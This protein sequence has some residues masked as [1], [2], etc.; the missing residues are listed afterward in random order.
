MLD[1]A[2]WL[3]NIKTRLGYPILHLAISDEMIDKQI[4][5]AIKKVVPYFN[6]TEVFTIFDRVTEFKDKLIYSV[7]RVSSNDTTDQ[8][9]TDDSYLWASYYYNT[10]SKSIVNTALWNYYTEEVNNTLFEVG[11]RFLGN[12]LYI[13]NGEP[14]YTVEAITENSLQ[15]MSEDY[16]NWC[17]EYSL[18]LVKVIEG[19]IR[20]KLKIEGSPIETNGSELK[21]E[22]TE[23]ISKLEE[24]LGSSLSLY[25]ATR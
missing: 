3:D 7:I 6:S 11:F 23:E 5:Y 13:D 18:A 12:T 16:V 19:E 2:E 15:N 1:R 4:T 20:S 17:F 14:P 21:A 25:Y 8:K 10:G 24:K 9:L 22:G